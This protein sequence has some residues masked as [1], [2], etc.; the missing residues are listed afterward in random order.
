MLTW[1]SVQWCGAN[2]ILQQ[3]I[4][5]LQLNEQVRRMQSF[6]IRS[7]EQSL[8]FISNRLH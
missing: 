7:S 2:S 6:K 3:E 1:L 4:D 8:K 5:F